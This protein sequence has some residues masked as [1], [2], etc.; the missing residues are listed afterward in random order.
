M[1]WLP[2]CA[3]VYDKI[4]KDAGTKVNGVLLLPLFHSTQNAQI[5]VNVSTEG[6]FAFATIIDKANQVTM[7]P[8][9]EDSVARS[10][11]KEIPHPLFDKLIYTAGDFA[12]YAN[13]VN[14]KTPNYHIEYMNKLRQWV[15]SEYTNDKLKAVYKYLSKG[16]LA[17]DLINNELLI[18]DGEK[19]DTKCKINN[20]H[21]EDVFIRFSVV[22]FETGEK[23]NLWDDKDISDK[24]ISYCSNSNSE[25]E[26]CYATGEKVPVTYKHM[27]GIRYPG[28]KS[29]LISSNDKTGFTYRGL[30]S[31]KEE[32]YAVGRIVSQKAHLA[33]KWLSRS[34]GT[35]FGTAKYI[36]WQKSL[37]EVID[38]F[39]TVKSKN[40]KLEN[41]DIKTDS[42]GVSYAKTLSSY[43]QILRYV[44]KGYRQNLN[45]NSDI[46]I[47]VLDAATQGRMS[48]NMYQELK[49]SEFYDNVNR[50]FSQTVWH[51]CYFDGQKKL[52][53]CVQTPSL[54]NIIKYA[55]GVEKDSL[56]GQPTVE[57]DEKV[58]QRFV[59]A[60]FPCIALGKPLPTNV[61]K[62][63][64]TRASNPQFYSNKNNWD[65]VVDV[66][67]A[68]YRKYY[69]DKK[70]VELNMKL[71]RDCD[72]RSYL[73]GRLA[74]VAEKIE[75][76]TYDSDE[77]RAPNALR[78]MNV[79]I[80]SPFKTW[81]H[82]EVKINLYIT[83]L[84]S[85][86]YGSYTYYE[87]ELQE[88]YVNFKKGD[89]E[90]AK[91]LDAMFFMGYYG[92]KDELY[93]SSKNKEEEK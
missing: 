93:T 22:N 50:W 65:R 49:S 86:K 13:K 62:Q 55:C 74:A 36:I 46:I 4:G 5:E 52:V 18:L 87:K 45:F 38:C 30:F 82:I 27:A 12:K 59:Q 83:K 90:L 69:I 39:G 16:T 9:T 1:S 56:I 25:S 92:E 14:N 10:S 20:I 88:I 3:A 64:F 73:Y 11:S 57:V 42:D 85:K 75:T 15:E 78:Y 29:K 60:I 77:K 33:L 81:R 31:T 70:G 23:V 43:K 8:V 6:E 28:D 26:L 51:W 71:D 63:I 79:L 67:C 84:A 40:T 68:L 7:I 48:I 76:D 2:E 91:P 80:S 72:D 58:L 19:F 44:M 89:F 24:Y 37:E 32:A 61:L 21:Q 34:C 35:T 66:C 47:M 54:Y 41:T 17:T 53:H